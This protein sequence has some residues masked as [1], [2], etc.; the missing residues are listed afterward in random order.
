MLSELF[1]AANDIAM[2]NVELAE[3]D[4]VPEFNDLS[5]Y[6]SMRVGTTADYGPADFAA[7]YLLELLGLDYVAYIDGCYTVTDALT[8]QLDD[9]MT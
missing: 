7:G 8:Q 1:A 3:L 6:E 2:V 9:A 4:F 5:S